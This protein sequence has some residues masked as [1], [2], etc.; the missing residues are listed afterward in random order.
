MARSA[1]IAN[2]RSA[3]RELVHLIP[4]VYNLA[5]YCWKG[6]ERNHA[7]PCVAPRRADRW[8][9][10]PHGPSANALGSASGGFCTRRRVDRANRGSQPPTVVPARVI[11]A[12]PDQVNDAGLQ[13]GRRKHY[14]QRF[15]HAFEA[16]GHGDQDVVDTTRL[17]VVEDLHP[18][19]GAF[20]A[21]DPQTQDIA[22]AVGQNSQCKVDRLVAHDRIFA[23][24]DPQRV[25]EHDRVHRLKPPS[26]PGG[27]FS[28]DLV[29]DR[30]DEIGRDLDI[31][32]L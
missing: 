29:G 20:G 17:E 32:L 11:E 12:I 7:I 6:E 1:N 30:A 19:P 8:E 5:N 26:P 23:N 10:L 14:R 13:R 3:A 25:N 31:V 4:S 9:F 18:E 2:E 21:F 27:D 16:I 22:C 24:L 28:H 15:G